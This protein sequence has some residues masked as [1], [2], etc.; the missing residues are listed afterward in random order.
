MDLEYFKIYIDRLSDGRIESISHLFSPDF[1]EQNAEDLSF[2]S[3]VEVEGKVYLA[4][5]ELVL[6]LDVRTEAVLPCSICNQ[7]VILPV[8]L[9][10]LYHVE[11]LDKIK[12]AIFI[13]KDILREAILLE[14]PKFTECSNGNCPMRS[15]YSRYLSDDT[16][17]DAD[18]KS[19]DGGY[20]PFADLDLN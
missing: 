1:L 8:E 17:L 15:K 9:R 14:V 10:N 2:T 3:P 18:T 4:G 7:P 6:Q 20:R 13:F 5:N 12:S 19:D 16:K 11:A